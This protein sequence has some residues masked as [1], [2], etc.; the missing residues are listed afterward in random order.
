MVQISG[1]GNHRSSSQWYL[2][3]GCSR[4][5]TGDRKWLNN[6]K[7]LDGGTVTFGDSNKGKI[8]GIGE[9]SIDNDVL[10]KNILFV[11][12]LHHNLISISQLCD[13][14]MIVEFHRVGC[15]I[16]DEET[17]ELLFVGHRFKNIYI[18]NL[19]EVRSSRMCLIAQY[20]ARQAGEGRE[21][22]R[23]RRGREG[24][25]GGREGGREGR[26]I[27]RVRRGRE[28]GR[29]GERGGRTGERGG[30]GQERER[31]REREVDETWHP[32]GQNRA[33]ISCLPNSHCPRQQRD[34]Y[35][36]TLKSS[37]LYLTK[38][39]FGLISGTFDKVKTFL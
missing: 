18:V 26:E 37:D 16:L 33:T 27:G 36:D 29:E 31:E 11:E 6:V 32:G 4:H 34:S 21:G 38:K 35:L 20:E 23:V 5:M 8:K 13:N 25:E 24:G 28:G 39:K 14:Q 2:D 1:A 3:S 12:G 7:N 22:G 15:K 9:I 17:R 10:V 30:G 19:E